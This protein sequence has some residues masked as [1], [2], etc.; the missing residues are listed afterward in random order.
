M[1]LSKFLYKSIKLQKF[2]YHISDDKLKIIKKIVLSGNKVNYNIL[3][4]YIYEYDYDNKYNKLFNLNKLN[5]LDEEF[6]K[7]L[8]L[9]NP[10]IIQNFTNEII[11]SKNIQKLVV[12]HSPTT[13]RL[14]LE[15]GNILSEEVLSCAI[16][17]DRWYEYNCDDVF[18][19]R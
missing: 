3:I 4:N 2:F 12:Y 5:I 9:G 11:L 8:V 6:Q 15:N 17:N 16:F 7:Y 13:I 14:L 1:F 18:F 10:Y 19:S